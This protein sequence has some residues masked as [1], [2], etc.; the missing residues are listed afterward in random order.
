MGLNSDYKQACNL[1]A[2]LS[3][4]DRRRL[5]KICREVQTAQSRLLAAAEGMMMRCREGC[6]GLCCRNVDL[7]AII[8]PWDLV[9]I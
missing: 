7:N 1:L 3:D 2:R 5:G 4:P 8:S 9:Y 6:Q